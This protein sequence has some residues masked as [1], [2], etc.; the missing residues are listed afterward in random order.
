MTATNELTTRANTLII[1][2]LP[3]LESREAWL[4]F[5]RREVPYAFIKTPECLVDF[6]STF[7]KITLPPEKAAYHDAIKYS[8]GSRTHMEPVWRLIKGCDWSLKEIIRGLEQMDFSSNV[9]DNS[10]LK[11]HTD[12]SV[13]KYFSRERNLITPSD[14]GLLQPHYS[15]PE[16]WSAQS[17]ARLVSHQQF[18]DLRSEQ[19]LLGNA[20][21]TQPSDLPTTQ[22]ILML[23]LDPVEQCRG[24][25]IEERL[26]IYRGKQPFISLVPKLEWPE[27]RLKAKPLTR[28][29]L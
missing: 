9:R 3:Q 29:A 8:L 5:C 17:L 16:A 19:K 26:Y 21:N 12:L 23:L 1:P 13:R 7:L 6:Q 4:T 20:Q 10:L 11:L 24:E 25:V 15:A 27:P 28:Y 22:E 14:I 18:T 2:V